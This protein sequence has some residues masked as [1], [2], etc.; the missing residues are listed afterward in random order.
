MR[1]LIRLAVLFL[2]AVGAKSL[3]DRI[4][5]NKDALRSSGNRFLDATTS[6]AREVGNTLSGASQNVGAAVQ[7][8]AADVRATA[9]DQAEAVK[10]AAEDLKS[11]TAEKLST[12][13]SS[14]PG[15]PASGPS[16]TN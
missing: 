7:E 3:Y 9:A 16:S 11:E 15:T 13:S 2:A 14:S 5:P 4:A 6:A 1:T 12:A 10:A 8:G